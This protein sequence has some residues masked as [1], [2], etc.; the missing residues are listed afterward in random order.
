MTTTSSQTSRAALLILIG[1]ATLGFSD[2][3]VRFV[4][5]DS[6][7]WQFHL[8][9][10]S[11]VLSALCLAAWFGAG[12]IWPRRPINVLGRS[13][14]QAGALLIYFGCIAI[15]PIGVVVAGLFT[16]PLF[17]LIIGVVFQSKRVGLI[18]VAAVAVGFIGAVLVIDPDPE[19]LDLISFL[20]VFAGLLYAIGAIATRAWCE[21]EETLTLTF[22]FFAL[23]LVF[24]VIGVL[25]LPTDGVAGSAGFPLRGWMP[26]TGAMLGWYAALA[27][28]ALIGIASIFRA[29]QIGEAGTVAI[30]EY[31]LLVFA[32]F[33]AWVLWG[34]GVPVQGLI[35]M[36]LIAAAG[37]AIA[38]RD[39]A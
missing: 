33:W 38:L 17:V 2:N 16:A 39:D 3:L 26:V 12:A 28:G 13:I 32:S 30:F 7:L 1:M 14:F 5:T 24:G 6:S 15:M 27:I 31:T 9:R 22:W 35:G 34:E 20:P 36:A 25:V 21:G 10:S 23:L 4:T 19:A 37:A 11:L 18:R 29:Y 8:I